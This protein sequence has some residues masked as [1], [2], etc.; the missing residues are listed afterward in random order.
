MSL[1]ARMRQI[2]AELEIVSA[3][4]IYSYQPIGSKGG[5]SG[6]EPRTGDPDPPFV[7]FRRVYAA[8]VDDSG[9]EA[10]I[11]AAEYELRS[12]KVRT[13]PA[14]FK[15]VE[16]SPIQ[17]AD[18]LLAEGRGLP[19]QEAAYRL[20]CAPSE[21]QRIRRNNNCDHLG[22]ELREVPKEERKQRALELVENGLSVRDA[23]RSVGVH[24]TQVQ[25]WRRAA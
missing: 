11:R 10:V 22:Y 5:F 21:L 25:R 15:I 6:S 7:L 18:R 8:C 14:G 3:G 13:V 20:N 9:R 12:L 23:A 4:R 24:P 19:L 17:R 1:D 2:L 16:E